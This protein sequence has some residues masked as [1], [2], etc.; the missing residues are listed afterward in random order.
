MPS[1][2]AWEKA[3][4]EATLKVGTEVAKTASLPGSA[5]KS[6][7][8]SA[9]VNSPKKARGKKKEQE[10]DA[11][12]GKPSRKGKAN[13]AKKSRGGR[14]KAASSEPDT[15]ALDSDSEISGLSDDDNAGSP[16]SK[17]AE[18]TSKA[19]K[20]G[21]KRKKSAGA[22]ESEPEDEIDIM[23]KGLEQGAIRF[24]DDGDSEDELDPL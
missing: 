13:G 9:A 17:G 15:A 7:K 10:S 2:A 4:E 1:K 20:N 21:K 23:L 22:S 5:K 12:A 14:K 11:S 6:P 3:F 8:K 19:A 24:S 16:S 18:A